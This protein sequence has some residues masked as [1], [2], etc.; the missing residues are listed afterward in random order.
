MIYIIST[1]SLR[2]IVFLGGAGSNIRVVTG[3]GIHSK[4]AKGARIRPAVI[5]YLQDKKYKIM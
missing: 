5:N 3:Q 2:S 4:G 1:K